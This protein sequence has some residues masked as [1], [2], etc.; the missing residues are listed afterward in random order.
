MSFL[1]RHLNTM[2]LGID[3]CFKTKLKDCGITDPD[4]G[5]GLSYMVNDL[6][7]AAHLKETTGSVPSKDVVSTLLPHFFQ[8]SY[9]PLKVATCGSNLNA[10]NQVYTRNSKGYLVTGIVAVS[11][12]HSFVCPTGVVDLQKGEK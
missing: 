12:R 8:R 7:Y 4:L 6:D 11:C 5:T 2:F 9:H 10:V 1:S 3:G